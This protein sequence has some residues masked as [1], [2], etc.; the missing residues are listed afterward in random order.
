MSNDLNEKS[1]LLSFLACPLCKG[2]LKNVGINQVECLSY[3]A[4]YPVEDGIH[5]HSKS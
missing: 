1:I 3:N 2:C 4:A 5:E